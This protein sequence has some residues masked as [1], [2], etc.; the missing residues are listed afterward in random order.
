[1]TIPFDRLVDGR[2]D[3]GNERNTNTLSHHLYF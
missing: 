1:M 2:R 3:E